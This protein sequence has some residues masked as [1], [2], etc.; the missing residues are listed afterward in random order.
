MRVG[1][2]RS[3]TVDEMLDA[4]SSMFIAGPDGL[5]RADLQGVTIQEVDEPSAPPIEMC[6][7]RYCVPGM[8]GDCCHGWGCVWKNAVDGMG[9]VGKGLDFLLGKGLGGLAEVG[10][11]SEVI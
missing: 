3:A 6:A 10:W 7:A 11:C 1:I 2:G 4:I 8:G 5:P 9:A